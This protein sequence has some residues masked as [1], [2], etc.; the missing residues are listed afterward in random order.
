MPSR[1]VN[2]MKIRSHSGAQA[3]ILPICCVSVRYARLQGVIELFW[4]T[5]TNKCMPVWYIDHG[6][7]SPEQELRAEKD[8]GV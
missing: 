5:T 6:C 7:S 8:L 4:Q 3:T 1:Q 2:G